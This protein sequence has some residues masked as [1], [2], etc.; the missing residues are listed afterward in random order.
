MVD[1]LRSLA[2]TP[3]D[4]VKGAAHAHRPAV[5]LAASERM[6]A[7]AILFDS[8]VKPSATPAPA[9]TQS[10]AGGAEPRVRASVVLREVNRVLDGLQTLSTSRSTASLY[11]P[12]GDAEYAVG[13]GASAFT[14]GPSTSSVSSA[15]TAAAV[16]EALQLRQLE[17]EVVFLK[18]QLASEV[19]CK[20]ELQAAIDELRVEFDTRVADAEA[21]VKRAGET[22][23]A[24]V[25]ATEAAA[26]AAATE[27]TAAMQLL[28]TRL[29]LLQRHVD[30]RDADVTHA[31]DAQTA[32]EQALALSEATV[33]RMQTEVRPG[34]V[35]VGVALCE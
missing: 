33:E 9:T 19:S 15:A 5:V 4:V 14:A 13:G 25:A 10:K 21:R 30:E 24:R 1:N 27:S 35:L 22:A 16:T 6:G 29:A 12:S 2:S 23:D 34:C 26:A 32:A 28:H 7:D 31:R 18:S 20:D 17:N 11:A 8:P 3:V